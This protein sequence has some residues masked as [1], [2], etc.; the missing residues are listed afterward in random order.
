MQLTSITVENNEAYIYDTLGQKIGT[1]T[2]ASRRATPVGEKPNRTK[3]QE[4]RRRHAQPRDT[5]LYRPMRIWL[6]AVDI[7]LRCGTPSQ[8]T[9]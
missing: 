4:R 7:L 5:Q 9:S 6:E 3:T 8:N 2:Q 1:V